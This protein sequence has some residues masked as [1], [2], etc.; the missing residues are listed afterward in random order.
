MAFT[1]HRSN[2][3]TT[4]NLPLAPGTQMDIQDAVQLNAQG[5]G[6]KL[7]GGAVRTFAGFAACNITGDN[8]RTFVPLHTEGVVEVE[9]PGVNQTLLAQVV[10]L[11]ASQ[12]YTLTPTDNTPFGVITEYM[13]G[14]K[15][16]VSIQT[17]FHK[18]I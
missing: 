8:A 10:F 1:W 7:V 9:V 5:L 6:E 2:A 13:G 14:T 3:N 11:S 15:V 17:A 4:L 16:R 18:Q 12:T